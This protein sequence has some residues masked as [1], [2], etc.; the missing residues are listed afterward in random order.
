[1]VVTANLVKCLFGTILEIL[2]GQ[3][4]PA[5]R[6]IT[7]LLYP[8]SS[9]R[10]GDGLFSS[11]KQYYSY[12]PP[13][14]KRSRTVGSIG[15]F[16]FLFQCSWHTLS[17]WLGKP[18]VGSSI[19]PTKGIRSTVLFISSFLEMVR[20][21]LFVGFPYGSAGLLGGST[22]CVQNVSSYPPSGMENVFLQ[23]MILN[24]LY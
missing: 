20:R 2:M 21:L 19:L 16:P 11:Y 15:M 22:T 1:M 9:D 23:F 3:I 17:D 8:L 4:H 24:P 10:P 7:G 5:M 14:R 6:V 18:Q 12:T 13:L